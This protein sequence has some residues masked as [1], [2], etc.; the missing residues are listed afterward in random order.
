MLLTANPNLEHS[1]DEGDTAL[2]RAVRSKNAEMVQLLIDK[3]CKVNGADKKGDTCLHI[4]MR[5]RSKV[6]DKKRQ[7]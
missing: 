6:R 2:L 5:G 4:A 1:T 7:C 3:R